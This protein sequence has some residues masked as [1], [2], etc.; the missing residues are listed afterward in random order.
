MNMMDHIAE[1]DTS[2][3]ITVSAKKQQFTFVAISNG[4]NIPQWG[5]ENPHAMPEYVT[6]N[7]KTS[8]CS[9]L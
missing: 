9:K 8:L 3:Q 2:C 1:D 4:I 5:S 7:P 6:D